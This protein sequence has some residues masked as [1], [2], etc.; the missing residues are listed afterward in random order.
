MGKDDFFEKL[1]VKTIIFEK[2]YF[3]RVFLIMLCDWRLS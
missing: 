3:F 2:N 1:R